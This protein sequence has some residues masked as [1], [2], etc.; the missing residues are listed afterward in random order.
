MAEGY[1]KLWRSSVDNKFY[2]AEPF[3]K[4]QAWVDLLLLANHK[5]SWTKE[6]RGITIEI[7]RGQVMAGEEFLADRWKWSRGKVRRF[8]Q[9]LEGKTVQ[10]IVQQKNNII[11]II[12]IVNWDNYQ[13]DGTANS[14][15][16]EPSNSTTDGQQTDIIKKEKKEDN[17]TTPPIVPQNVFQFFGTHYQDITDKTADV[18]NDMLKEFGEESV[19]D[20]LK[21]GHEHKAHSL[22]YVEKVLKSRQEEKNRNNGH[23]NSTSYGRIPKDGVYHTMDDLYPNVEAEESEAQG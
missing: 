20:A 2:F 21:E 23:S 12:S 19:L 14:T 3:T 16:F 9:Q 4:W 7:K 15:T 8:L 17:N 22:K 11:T 13:S 5:D 18:L 6:V 1:I 10:Q